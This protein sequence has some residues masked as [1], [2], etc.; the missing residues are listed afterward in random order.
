[1]AAYTTGQKPLPKRCLKFWERFFNLR[2]R[3]LTV[4]KSLI[5]CSDGALERHSPPD[6][7]RGW[8]TVQRLSVGEDSSFSGCKFLF[9][10]LCTLFLFLFIMFLVG[11]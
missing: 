10:T 3:F 2:Q 8:R 9:R 4:A 1:M 11:I 7:V 5:C 6:H